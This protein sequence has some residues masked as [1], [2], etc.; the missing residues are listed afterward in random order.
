MDIETVAR[1]SFLE[2]VSGCTKTFDLEYYVSGSGGK[3]ERRRKSVTVDIPPG[4]DSD[5]Q[6][7]V[8][9]KGGDGAAG[10]PAGDLFVRMAVEQDPYFKREGLHVRVEVPL[11][12][13]QA[14]LGC[15]VEVLTLD[16]LVNMKVP[17]GTQPGA[18][19]MLKGKGVPNMQRRSDRGNQ[20][21]TLVVKL[22]MKVTEK[23][24]VLLEQFDEGEKGEKVETKKR[25]YSIEEAWKRV[26]TFLSKQ[27]NS[28]TK[29][30]G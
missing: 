12:F 3:R 5:V 22:P 2:A 29:G 28:S 10:M 26:S 24:K 27:Q 14:I 4:I 11:T 19:M 20:Y 8:P 1:L 30:Q 9:G 13:T 7:R 6:M 25:S 17:A 21:V 23:Q 18:Q 15:S 16:G